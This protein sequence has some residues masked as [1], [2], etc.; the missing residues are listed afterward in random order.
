M[1]SRTSF[2]DRRFCGHL[3]RRFWPLWLIWLTALLVAGPVS[4]NT[5]SRYEQ[6]VQY[7]SILRRELLNSGQALT[8][9]ALA[10][11]AL[12]AMGMLSYLYSPRACGLVN[13]LPLRRETVYFTAVLTGL[14]PMLVCDVLVF[15]LLHALYSGAGVGTRYFVQWLEMILLANV[16]FYGI[17]CFCGTLTGNVLVLPAVYAVLCCAAAVLEGAVHGV[18]A[19]LLYGYVNS[20]PWSEW[21]SP[22]VWF[23]DH[24][25]VKALVPLNIENGVAGEYETTW[26]PYL[27]GVCAVG[28]LLAALAVLILKKR[29]ME[30]AGDVVAVPVL[31]PIFRLCMA[32]GCGL[33]GSVVLAETFN[34]NLYGF[35]RFVLLAVLLVVFAALGWFVAEML[36]QK[37]LRVFDHG[38]KK[39]GAICACLLVF[40]LLTELDVTGFETRV[41]AADE[42]EAVDLSRWYGW[43]I[44]LTEPASIAAAQELQRSLIAHKAEIEANS[45][46]DDTT[47][48]LSYRLKNGKTLSRYYRI[49]NS[50]ANRTDPASDLAL[51]QKALNVPEAQL[52]RVWADWEFDENDIRIAQVEV[53]IQT[54][55]ENR[56]RSESI[57]L[58]SAQAMALY[59]EGI[60]PDAEAGNIGIWYAWTD[61][62][63]HAEQTG[64]TVEIIPRDKRDPDRPWLDTLDVQVLTM[65]ENTLR[66][67]K[68]NLNLDPAAS[69]PV[70]MG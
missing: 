39:V 50:E 49:P 37:T 57:P 47:I 7:M 19:E 66:W 35:K 6:P 64:F 18:F 4:L 65:S 34:V 5:L 22:P 20:S 58:T 24:A 23:T 55:E 14:V 17:A 9:L 63:T 26:I 46:R 40:A 68:E 67:L 51:W 12:M 25:S 41:P 21:L 13:S 70:N 32:V 27:A 60:L 33:V 62:H 48:P 69:F 31:R 56:Y 38:W 44:N 61:E 28:L 11:G 1:R 59:R 2:F 52:K 16:G 8:W 30:T 42:V 3:L 10:M 15:A 45:G 36:I 54:G 53:S 29:Q 43:D